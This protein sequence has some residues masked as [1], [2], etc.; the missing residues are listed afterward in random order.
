ML[1]WSDYDPDTGTVNNSDFATTM[2]PNRSWAGANWNGAAFYCD[3]PRYSAGT[4]TDSESRV[5]KVVNVYDN[6][7]V[8]SDNNNAAPRNDVIL[9]AIYE[10]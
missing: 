7:I 5:I 1:L 8:G 10:F 6:K 9:R 2:I 4:A 3:V